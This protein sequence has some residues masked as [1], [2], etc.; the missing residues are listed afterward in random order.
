M[1]I[2]FPNGPLTVG[3]TFTDVT[4]GRSWQWNGSQW[5]AV[6]ALITEVAIADNAISLSKLTTELQQLLVPTGTI[7]SYAGA[8]APAGWLMCD[9]ASYPIASYQTLY[10]TIGTAYNNPDGAA[11]PSA[12]FFR[13]PKLTGKVPVGLDGT[14]DFNTR[15]KTSGDK[16]V[17]LTAAQSGVPAHSHTNTISGGPFATST[18]T[19][20][21]RGTLAAA[22]GPYSGANGTLGYLYETDL[23][24]YP[25]TTLDPGS[26]GWGITN[27]VV[28][29]PTDKTFSNFVKVYG[30]TASASASASVGIVNADNTAAGATSGH[31]NLQ[32]YIVVNYIIKV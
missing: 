15:G 28:D 6:S 9:G 24:T 25:V 10:N 12:G 5:I 20:S 3:Q 31:N 4:S 1:A 11:S 19:H 26:N 30:S 13:V 18:H 23:T 29:T 17:T 16:S 32:P 7:N 21:A 8:S 27:L 22:I 2:D 14:A